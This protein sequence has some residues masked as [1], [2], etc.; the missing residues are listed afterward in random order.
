MERHGP[1]EVSNTPFLCVH[2]GNVSISHEY[3]KVS[4]VSNELCCLISK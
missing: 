4:N 3:T 1:C 2:L